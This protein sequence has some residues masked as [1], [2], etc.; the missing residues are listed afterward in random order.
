MTK[1]KILVWDIETS[2]LQSYTWGTWKQN[3]G[4]NQIKEDWHMLS[5]AAKW[6]GTKEVMYMD[7]RSARDVTNDKAIVAG[8]WELL[9]EADIV[10]TQ[11]GKAFD[12][13]KV[14]ARFVLHGLKPPRPYKHVDTLLLARK[15][16]AFTSNKLAYMTDKLCTKY[17]KLTD[18]K[19]EGFELWKEC[20]KGNQAAWREMERYNKH[21]VLALEELYYKLAPWDVSV[22]RTSEAGN[23]RVCDGVKLQSR[24][25]C[26]TAAGRYRRFQCQ[27]CGAW[28]R[29]SENELGPVERKKSLR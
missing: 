1:P 25:S 8:L 2:P 20:L 6:I 17:K 28:Q 9:N 18:H 11:N 21:D 3:V 22:D 10:I 4:L 5:W 19:F 26:T 15:H 27:D 7:Q 13:K 12:S 16:F 23:C 14:N 29:G 24:G